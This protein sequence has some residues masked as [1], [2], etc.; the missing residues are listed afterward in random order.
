MK[1]V[2]CC[3]FKVQECVG[4]GC[5]WWHLNRSEEA[6]GKLLSSLS[7]GF[8]MQLT[9]L[10]SLD[11]CVVLIKYLLAWPVQ[12]Q[13]PEHTGFCFPSSSSFQRLGLNTDTGGIIKVYE[14]DS[15]ENVRERL[16]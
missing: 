15:D 1:I 13:N 14:R 4:I 6:V 3:D 16:Q 8:F 7:L 9:I 5:T 11:L 2:T 10:M 12:T